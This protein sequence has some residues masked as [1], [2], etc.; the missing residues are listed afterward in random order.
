MF[1]DWPHRYVYT[2]E[3]MPL[4]KLYFLLEVNKHLEREVFSG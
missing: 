2:M 3:L 1:A 4:E